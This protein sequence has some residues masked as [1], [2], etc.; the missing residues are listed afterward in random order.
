MAAAERDLARLLADPAITPAV[1]NSQLIPAA[2]KKITAARTTLDAATAARDAIPAKLPAN[3]IDPDA[4][5][6]LLRARRRGLQMVLRLL[7][8]NAEHWLSNQLN[9]YLRDDDEYRA[10]TRQP[11]SAA[12]P[13]ITWAPAAI[14][15][16]LD[17]PGAP[18]VARAL[19]LLIEQLDATPPAM[20]G[21]TRPITYQLAPPARLLIPDLRHIPEI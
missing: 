13:A 20:P 6:A 4:K 5:V 3:L 16:H 7:A 18:R 19:T 14:T 21:N 11:S 9:A 1:K 12:S 8:H 2:Q 15:V 10:I 17:R